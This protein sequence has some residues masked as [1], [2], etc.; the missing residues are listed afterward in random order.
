MNRKIYL[1]RM[2]FSRYDG[3]RCLVYLNEEKIENH[4]PADAPEGFKPVTAY[5][6]TGPEDDGGTLIEAADESRDALINGVI[7]SLYSQTE[8]DAIKTHQILALTNPGHDKA[9]DY[10]SEWARFNI[11][12]EEAIRTVDSWFE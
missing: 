3:G 11:D 9:A 5:A 1:E 2:T 10:A 7:R 6:Y 4:V 8:E 12:R